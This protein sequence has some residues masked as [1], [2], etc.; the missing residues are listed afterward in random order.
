MQLEEVRAGHAA[1]YALCL[2]MLDEAVCSPS[3]VR[4]LAAGDGVG[5]GDVCGIALP[6]GGGVDEEEL[7]A[8]QRRGVERVVQRGGVAPRPDDRVVRLRFGEAR[9]ARA[10][11]GRFE[12]RLVRGVARAECGQDSTV[13]GGGD[14]VRVPDQG[15]LEGRFVDAAGGKGRGEVV[16]CEDEGGGDT[17]G[18]RG[19][20]GEVVDR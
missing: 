1:V 14:R 16:G 2:H 9:G 8:L 10:E 11:E 7:P 15:D 12:M 4:D 20:R 3:L 5:A 13:R 19:V 18:V 6:L 17:G